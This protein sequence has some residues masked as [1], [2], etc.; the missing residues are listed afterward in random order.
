MILDFRFVKGAMVKPARNA[1]TKKTEKQKEIEDLND[2][3]ERT[4]AP[5]DS[6]S[7]SLFKDL[8]LSQNTLKGL[9][10]DE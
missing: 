4:K 3:I 1:Q 7:L 10:A 2:L 6:K 9:I 5:F 8:P